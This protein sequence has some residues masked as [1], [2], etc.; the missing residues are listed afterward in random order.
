MDESRFRGKTGDD[1]VEA[2]MLERIEA[3]MRKYRNAL[4][5]ELPKQRAARAREI[6]DIRTRCRDLIKKSE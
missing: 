5:E 6:R 4:K 1:L 2:I 3:A